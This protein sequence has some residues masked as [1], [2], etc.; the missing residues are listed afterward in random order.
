VTGNVEDK[1]TGLPIM[2]A[3]VNAAT[4]AG[5]GT[6][7]TTDADGN[8]AILDVPFDADSP[9]IVSVSA[10]GYNGAID[11]SYLPAC[12]GIAN[13]SFQLHQTPKSRILLYYGNCGNSPDLD[14]P[15]IPP[16][17]PMTKHNYFAAAAVFEYFGYQVDYY[18]WADWPTDPDLEEYKVIFL[19]G[20]GNMCDDEPSTDFT[21]GQVAQLD[22]FLRNGGRLVVMSDVSGTTNTGAISVENNLLGA[23]N[24]LD[25]WFSDDNNDGLAD[26]II[27][28]LADDLQ[29]LPEQLLGGTT[30]NVH[31]L[32]FN[33]AISVTIDAGGS[34]PAVPGLIAALDA[35][36]PRDGQI[37]AAADTMPG[38]T[39]LA[40]YNPV[41]HVG[42][43]FAGD[44]VVIGDKDWMDDPSFMGVISDFD[45]DG[46]PDFVF[47][48][49]PADNENLLL[50]IF[51]F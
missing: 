31:T 9:V 26:G 45:N 46:Q 2:G 21:P 24:D 41:T 10:V 32:D 51:T 4:L 48:D 42:A 37:I 39:R 15:V 19:L 27:G 29:P 8:Y 16:T 12:G 6:T 35:P 47:P 23:L 3:E 1:E 5:A 34:P 14:D 20:P 44:V 18:N 40:G 49:W 30:F 7:A 36:H 33:T 13:I 11:T 25:V 50:N 28:A 22:L 43:G 17:T 38:V